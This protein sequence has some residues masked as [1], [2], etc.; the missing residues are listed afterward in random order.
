MLPSAPAARR[1]SAVVAL[2]SPP[3]ISKKST[4]DISFERTC[5]R[6]FKIRRHLAFYPR[7]TETPKRHLGITLAS[8]RT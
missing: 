7:L 1:V 2:A 3:P 5:L 6:L 4:T 8:R